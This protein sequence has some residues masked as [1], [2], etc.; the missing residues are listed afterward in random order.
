MYM[1]THLLVYS[2]HVSET[3]T[4]DQLQGTHGEAGKREGTWIAEQP[5]SIPFIR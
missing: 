2:R 1:H 4:T 3:G 5:A